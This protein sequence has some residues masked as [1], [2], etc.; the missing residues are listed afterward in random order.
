MLVMNNPPYSTQEADKMTISQGGH[1]FVEESQVIFENS[2][3]LLSCY[4]PVSTKMTKLPK[5]RFSNS[6]RQVS[7]RSQ[8]PHN[9]DRPSRR[10]Q[11]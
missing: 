3:S 9:G 11:T 6:Q 1:S 5:V 8:L 2:F 10:K 4:F 7:N